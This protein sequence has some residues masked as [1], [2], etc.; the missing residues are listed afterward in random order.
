MMGG[1]ALS[2]SDTGCGN[3]K[4]TAQPLV[5]VV[6]ELS[7][8]GVADTASPPARSRGEPNREPLTGPARLAEVTF[9]RLK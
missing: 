3:S 6:A 1:S 4:S 2:V 5:R 9:P 8:L 7:G